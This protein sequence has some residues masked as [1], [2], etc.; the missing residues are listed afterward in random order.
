MRAQLRLYASDPRAWRVHCMI[1]VQAGP[2][3]GWGGLKNEVVHFLLASKYSSRILGHC[4]LAVRAR[5]G[6][7]SAAGRFQ[8]RELA[9]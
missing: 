9:G 7:A 4:V 3:S 1:L 8:A 5:I 2:L 6:C